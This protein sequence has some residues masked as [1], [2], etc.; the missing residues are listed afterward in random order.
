MAGKPQAAPEAQRRAVRSP[1]RRARELVLQG[2][3]QWQVSGNDE[4]AIEA[5]LATAKASTRLTASS[6]SA[7]CAGSR[8]AQE[9]RGT[10]T[11]LSRSSLH[12]TVADRGL[13]S[14]GGCVRVEQLPADAISGD[15]Q[16]I[17]RT[18]QGLW[19]HRRSQVRQRRSRQTGCEPASGRGR[20]QTR[21]ARQKPLSS[22]VRLIGRANCGSDDAQ[23]IRTDPNAISPDQRR[24]RSSVPV[25]IALSLPRRQG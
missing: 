17:N 10:A 21:G 23:R 20:S 6:S 11:V 9:A 13:R 12:R 24:R 7:C 14:A 5:H 15:H 8:S 22:V 19:W 3:Y 16:R 1:R 18:G 4:A 25:T 2:L